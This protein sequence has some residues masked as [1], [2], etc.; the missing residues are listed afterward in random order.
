MRWSVPIWTSRERALRSKGLH[1]RGI[2]GIVP[3][4]QGIGLGPPGTPRRLAAQWL[5][6]SHCAK[7]REKP[8]PAGKIFSPPADSGPGAA[9]KARRNTVCRRMVGN[10]GLLPR[11]V[12]QSPVAF[13]MTDVE[14]LPIS[15]V[16]RNKIPML[17]A[18][19]S[20]DRRKNPAG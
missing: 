20:G 6:N 9:Q 5:S 2:G 3:H 11:P 1:Q 10:G 18:S 19:P 17:L 14:N 7:T 4:H 8:S 16:A 13:L 12:Y 15:Y